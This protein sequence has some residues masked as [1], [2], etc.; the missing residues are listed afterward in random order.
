[1]IDGMHK[2][3]GPIGH[4]G[5]N[6]PTPGLLPVLMGINGPH[7]RRQGGELLAKMIKPR[8][9]KV[10]QGDEESDIGGMRFNDPIDAMR[11]P[12]LRDAIAQDQTPLHAGKGPGRRRRM[13]RFP[14]REWS[15]NV[16]PR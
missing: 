6:T 8:D 2:L 9:A 7:R 10:Q 3:Q 16:H 5:L 14:G 15:A 13:W 1:M 4:H 12:V 11:I